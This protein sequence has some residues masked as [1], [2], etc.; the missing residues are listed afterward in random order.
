M[1]RPGKL[2][3]NSW[4]VNSVG[5]LMGINCSVIKSQQMHLC[6]GQHSIPSLAYSRIVSTLIIFPLLYQYFFF[7]RFCHHHITCC[8][9]FQLKVKNKTPFTPLPVLLLF[10]LS[11]LYRKLL[12]RYCP[13]TCYSYLHPLVLG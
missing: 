11:V 7:I 9:S 8:I 4:T 6:Q 1:E 2:R 5:H 13:Y 12:R 10:H 3:K